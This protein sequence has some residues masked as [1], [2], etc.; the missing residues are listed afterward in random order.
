MVAVRL[1]RSERFFARRSDEHGHRFYGWADRVCFARAAKQKVT[2]NAINYEGRELQDAVNE[3]KNLA[4]PQDWR[5][6]EST[7]PENTVIS[8]S[9]TA[10]WSSG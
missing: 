8:G 7:Q 4:R 3:L 5:G 10:L 2:V 1:I 6:V 9:P